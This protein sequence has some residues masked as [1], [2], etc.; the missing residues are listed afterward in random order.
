MNI[1][2]YVLRDPI[3]SDIRYVGQTNDCKR[4]LNKHITNSKSLKDSRHISNWIRSLSSSPIMDIIEVCD[5][6]IRNE[7]ENYW[8][9]HYK[10]EGCDLCNSSKGGAGAGIGNKN[11]LGR[12]IS[13]ETRIKMSNANKGKIGRKSNCGGGKP[14]TIYQYN[15]DNELIA[16][17]KSIQEVVKATNINRSTIRRN[18]Q[19]IS[20]SKLF[21]WT[22][23]PL[24]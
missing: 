19:G 22:D 23:E 12:V 24:H 2:I 10:D 3:N 20:S 21:I 4:R 7:R 5:Y 6:S 1:Y 15:K 9:N 14:K 17:Y 8:I 18:I 16:V 11:C 13:K